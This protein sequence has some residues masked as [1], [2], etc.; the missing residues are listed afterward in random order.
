MKE[1]IAPFLILLAGVLWGS[2]GI[3]VHTL[4]K[5]GIAA[6]NIVAIRSVITVIFTAILL[7]L[8]K[9]E[10]LKVKIRDLWCFLGTGLLSIVF[11]NYC[12][13][14]A[15][16][17]SSM[18]VAAVLLYSAPAF[19]MVF[20]WFLFKE[21]LT[22]NK[23]ISLIFVIVGCILVTGI[24]G[25]HGALSIKAVFLGLGAGLGYALYS[26][27]GRFALEKGYHSLTI[28]L[29]TFLFATVGILPLAD[30]PKIYSVVTGSWENCVL[31]LVFGLFSTLIPYFSYTAG[32]S[33]VENGK[34]SVIAAIE[35]VVAAL[36]GTALYK[37]S[38]TFWNVTGMI[39]VLLSIVL[40]NKKT[41]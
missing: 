37:E 29:Y 11:F 21:K 12:Y 24:A 4:N 13:F 40:A 23:W 16:E 14:S 32:L 28:L 38:L 25:D 41:K 18:A 2:M 35:P 6:I 31:I 15:I 27:F 7:V 5:L 26:I 1:K 3:F 19:V 34:A 30:F 9:P 17:I 39:L 36:L 20:S 10:L 8:L 22:V 33:C